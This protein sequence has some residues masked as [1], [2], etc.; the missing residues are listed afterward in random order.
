MAE[1][2]TAEVDCGTAEDVAGT[3]PGLAA[4]HPETI[5]AVPTIAAAPPRWPRKFSRARFVATTRFTSDTLPTSDSSYPSLDLH[6]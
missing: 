3:P 6:T 1:G 2:G 4:E 5:R